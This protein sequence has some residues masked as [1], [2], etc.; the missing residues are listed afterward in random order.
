MKTTMNVAEIVVYVNGVKNGITP[1]WTNYTTLHAKK[2]KQSKE[3]TMCK[4]EKLKEFLSGI[5]QKIEELSEMVIDLECHF[6]RSIDELLI[7]NKIFTNIEEITWN[8]LQ[9]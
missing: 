4:N 3:K 5:Q 2:N 1:R 7:N 9:R 6:N 8:T